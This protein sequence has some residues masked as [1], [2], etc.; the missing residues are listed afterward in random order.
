MNLTEFLKPSGISPEQLLTVVGLIQNGQGF[1]TLTVPKRRSGQN[2][3]IC[4]PEESISGYLKHIKLLIRDSGMYSPPPY[5]TGYVEGSGIIANARHHLG[6]DAV[7]SI[8]L[9]DFFGSIGISF[10]TH[11]IAR[12]GADDEVAR[13]LAQISCPRGSLAAGFHP[14]P[15]LSNIAFSETDSRIE[16]F[17]KS[18]EVNY[19]RYADDLTFSGSSEK[20]DDNFLYRIDQLLSS[21]IWSINHAKTR[22]MRRGGAQYVTGLYVG[23]P[24]NPH[25]PRR[26][27]RELRLWL[28]RFQRDSFAECANTYPNI[29]NYEWFKGVINY[30]K[31]VDPALGRKMESDF[32]RAVSANPNITICDPWEI[33]FRQL[34][35]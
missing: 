29:P 35:L 7:L 14:S 28:H 13:V 21:S 6:Q 17:C 9:Q 5:V 25:V 27:K 33:L 34:G 15:V 26:L 4:V 2:R 31:C 23:D 8:D 24:H 10:L 30:I 18:L 20:I 32:I 3:L 1:H 12:L 16:G 22:F 11:A 19:S